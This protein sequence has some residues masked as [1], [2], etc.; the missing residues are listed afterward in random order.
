[1]IGGEKREADG[2]EGDRDKIRPPYFTGDSGDDVDCRI[3]REDLEFDLKHQH[4][5]PE[6]HTQHG[7]DHTDEEPLGHEEPDDAPGSHPHGLQNPDVAAFFYHTHRERT[8][9][10]ECGNE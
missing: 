10:V 1:M 6:K 8:E 3:E 9:H 2:P 4:S 7:S 5:E